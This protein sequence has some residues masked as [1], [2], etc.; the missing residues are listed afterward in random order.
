MQKRYL[1]TKEV[2]TLLKVSIGTIRL[3]TRDNRM[4]YYKINRHVLFDEDEINNWVASQ[5]QEAVS[6]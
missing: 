5:K 2:A 1:T 6:K 4:P 3:W